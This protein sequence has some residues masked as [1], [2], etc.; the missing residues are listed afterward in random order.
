MYIH[1]CRRKH[2]H[3]HVHTYVHTYIHNCAYIHTHVHAYT[4]TYTCTYICT[5][6]HTYITVHTCI[7]TRVHACIHACIHTYIHTHIHTNRHKHIHTYIYTYKYDLHLFI[8]FG[9]AGY[10]THQQAPQVPTPSTSTT[11]CTPYH[12][13]MQVAYPFHQP[14]PARPHARQRL[15]NTS[16]VPG[17]AQHYPATRC[18]PHHTIRVKALFIHISDRE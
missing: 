4:H 10:P 9:P 6:I 5:Y 13:A 15:R 11:G 2:I 8:H 1:T 16:Y 3:T 12:P 14:S 17:T 7:H 18:Y